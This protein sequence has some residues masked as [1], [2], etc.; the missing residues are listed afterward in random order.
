MQFIPFEEPRIRPI[1]PATLQ[2]SEPIFTP[3]L[4]MDGV[5]ARS[6][7]TA[8]EAKLRA[9]EHAIFMRKSYTVDGTHY[10]QKSGA[11]QIPGDASPWEF[12]AATRALTDYALLWLFKAAGDLMV[13]E[14]ENR[15][16][17]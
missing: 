14:R 4:A 5:A 3:E 17:C 9:I 11:M 13:N 15:Q 1:P 2:L 7:Q 16:W 8:R 10:S 12:D 6:A